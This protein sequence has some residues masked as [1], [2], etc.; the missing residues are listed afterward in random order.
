MTHH[1]IIIYHADCVDGFTAAWAA[2][3]KYGDAAEYVPAHYGDEPPDVT[4]R[5]VL[6][7]DFSYPRS[8]LL[9]MARVASSIGVFDHHKT[10]RENLAGLDWCIFDEG[11][12]GAGLT[13]DIL[14]GRDTRPMLVDYVEDRDLWRWEIHDSREVSAYIATVERTF[15]QWDSLCR[16]LETDE[17]RAIE[18]G[19]VALRVTAQYVEHMKKRASLEW[20]AGYRV[21]CINTTFAHSELIGELAE[22][23]PFAAGWFQR[24]DGVLV[25]SLRSRRDGVDVAEIARRFGGGG[26]R[27][28]AGF[29]S[30]YVPPIPTA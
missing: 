6:I 15:E 2:W 14:H 23:H 8:T 16:E 25:Y 28:A 5:E 17:K 18:K 3:R 7:V 12:S 30:E 13:W 1:P 26:H 19:R 11:R 4:G 10:A 20:I 21:P 27:N 24:A 9:D 22:G 29:T